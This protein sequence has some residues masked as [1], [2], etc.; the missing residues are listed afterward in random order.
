MRHA[1]LFCLLA[2][3]AAA[4]AATPLS[5]A[6]FAAGMPLTLA[7][8][9]PFHRI[10]LPLAVYSQARP[11]LA[12]VRV[13][14]G[15]GE[16]VPYTVVKGK[17]PAAP[18]APVDVP[19]F[20]L[21]ASEGR[22]VAMYVRIDADGHLIAQTRSRQTSAA[23]S[24]LLDL[25]TVKT[26]VQAVRLDW[27]SPAGGVSTRVR[28]AGSNDLDQWVTVA[29][30]P[31]LD[32]EYGGQRLQQKRIE[33]P[34]ARFRYLWVYGSSALPP[35]TASAVEPV[36]ALVP[37]TERWMDVVGQPDETAGDYLF[38]L[39]AYVT[40]THL[41]L[42]LPQMNSLAPVTWQVRGSRDDDWRD[43]VRTTV[44][45]VRRDTGEVSSP[46]VDIG[47]QGG[48]YWRLHVDP[49]AGGIG[50]GTVILHLGWAPDEL[51]FVARGSPPFTLAF[52]DRHAPSA[53]LPLPSLL[54]GYQSGMEK[55]L[56]L[57]LPGITHPL[58]G[59]DAPTAGQEDQP[60][61]DWK[62]WLLWGVLLAAVGL[63]ALMGQ[64]LLRKSS[65]RS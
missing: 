45:R 54:P 52:G 38:D 44:Y 2:L 31:V 64:G 46:A 63:L 28:I 57:A 11:D 61:P 34:A 49:R 25:S 48:R 58:G 27:T 60:P 4:H 17:G 16:A 36:A 59:H 22:S 33:F 14:N 42:R 6:D 8:N 39:G 7:A 13:F 41:Q 1:T 32:I 24:W 12:D 47:R 21:Q 53:T 62:R 51:V 5:P 40:A 3:A 50:D 65:G 15:A 37:P 18:V 29:D 20:P 43:V 9:Q 35:L 26:P 56:P 10:E 55:A 23:S 19:R 30:A